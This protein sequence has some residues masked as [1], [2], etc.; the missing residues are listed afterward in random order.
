MPFQL[1]GKNYGN[2][3]KLSLKEVSL[4]EDFQKIWSINKDQIEICR[5]CEFRHICTDCRAFLKDSN[6][7]YSKPLK[8]S[9]NPYTSK[10]I[11]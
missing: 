4:R 3:E 7:T 8:C 10:W 5:D 11:N 1:C 2:I 6:N 9:Y